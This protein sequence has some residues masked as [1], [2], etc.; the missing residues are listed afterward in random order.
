VK[1]ATPT[2]SGL[3]LLPQMGGMLVTSIVS[4]QL[5]SRTGRY[6]IFPVVG[7]A[8]MTLGLYLLSRV[9]PEMSTTTAALL[10]LVV[11]LG[12]G[13]IM[14]VLVVAVQNAVEYREL[15]VATSGA[16]LFRSIGGSLGTAAL[17]AVF[18]SRLNAN[19]AG[20]LPHAGGAGINQAAIDALPAPARAAFAVAFTDALGTVF[21][22]A[23]VIA[24]LGFAI[25]LLLP[26][27]PLRETVA[28]A[29]EEDVGGDVGE[30]FSMPTDDDPLPQLLRGLRAFADRDVQRAHIQR[31]IDRAGVDLS[32][33][34]AW[35]L[36]RLGAEPA[37]DPESLGR[38][39]GISAERMRT[40][41][42]ELS[43][44][45]LVDG[46][47]P[48]APSTRALTAAGGATFD[49]L[50]AARRARLAELFA[51]WHPERHEELAAL[52]DRI[53][54]ELVPERARGAALASTE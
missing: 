39:Y 23:T 20:T 22:V 29:T 2:E 25:V 1:G 40:A 5:I 10:M 37:L 12:M 26:E 3:Q 34:A 24:A 35:L 21:L 32:P 43:D 18:A 42:A 45:G 41:A 30:A 13:M 46:A 49:R 16:T 17:G 51:E 38:E 33:A 36:L 14:Q 47:T 27:R 8:V 50:S 11:G 15:G 54:R 53:A 52:L 9:T 28:V 44:R 7:M 4:G 31:I 48:V 19:L 6:K